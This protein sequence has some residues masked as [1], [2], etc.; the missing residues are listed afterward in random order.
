MKNKSQNFTNQEKIYFPKIKGTKGD[1]LEYYEKIAATILPYLKD[2]PES[3]NRH[4]NGVGK[5]SFYQKNFTTPTPPYVKTWKR[6]SESTEENVNYLVCQNKE[7]LLYMANL[8]CIEINPWNSRI[9]DVNYP[10]WMV[11]DLDPP[12]K[13]KKNGKIDFDSLIKVAQEVK[14]VLDL[15]C[16]KSYVKTS[17]KTGIHIFIPLGGR[18]DYAHIRNFSHLLVQIVHSRLPELTT[19]ER[20]PAK[21]ENK[22]YLDYLQNSMG[23]TLAAP[24]SI[25]PT[26]DATVSTPLKWSEVK[27]GLDP[28]KFTIK[29]IFPRLKKHGDLWKGILKDQVDLKKAIV[30]LE[31]NMK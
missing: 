4:P 14:K 2:R 22:I 16:E 8:G 6:K 21:R 31:K 26:P 11:I 13:D 29:T 9:P 24:Y 30:C 19:I 18:Y 12:G 17:G 5:P 10:D 7:T 20:K 1:V 28:K 15:S 3:L 25:R 27:K 23:Q